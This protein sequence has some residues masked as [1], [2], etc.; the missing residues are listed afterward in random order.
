[1]QEDST[2]GIRDVDAANAGQMMHRKDQEEHQ[3]E[4]EHQRSGL[5]DQAC[6][7]E[8]EFMTKANETEDNGVRCFQC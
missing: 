2:T 5:N 8:G 3:L 7:N 1:M 4:V 6:T